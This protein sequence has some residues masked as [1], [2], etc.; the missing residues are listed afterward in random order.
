[1]ANSL[2]QSDAD[3]DLLK[4]QILQTIEDKK[5]VESEEFMMFLNNSRE[6]AF[7]YIEEVQAAIAKFNQ[8]VE[9]ILQEDLPSMTV[10]MK[11]LDANNEL[12]KQLPDN[13]KNNNVQGEL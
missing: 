1:M 7:S 11:I 12:Q 10:V 8:Q 5:L 3:K 13:I 2:L 9:K 6:A 4:K